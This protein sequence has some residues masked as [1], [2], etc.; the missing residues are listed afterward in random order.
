MGIKLSSTFASSATDGPLS[1][2]CF[3]S[4]VLISKPKKQNQIK[5]KSPINTHC[6]MYSVEAQSEEAEDLLYAFVFLDYFI[7]M[8]IHITVSILGCYDW[9]K[10]ANVNLHDSRVES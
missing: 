10:T 2:A 5:P 4:S 8:N 7:H 6:T 3:I 1:L 9:W